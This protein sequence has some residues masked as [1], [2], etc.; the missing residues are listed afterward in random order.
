MTNE[1]LTSLGEAL[2]T[3]AEKDTAELV[4]LR[5]TLHQFPELAMDEHLTASKIAEA[6]QGLPNVRLIRGF[7]IETS[8]IAVIR[9]DIEGDAIL[10][11]AAMDG[12]Q[13]MEET[14]LDFASCDPNVCHSSGHDAEMTALVGTVKLLSRF[15]DKLT[16]RVVVLF[17]PACEG[18]N[19]ARTLMENDF[20]S[21]FG[22]TSAFAVNWSQEFPYGTLCLRDGAITAIS[23][24]IHI[25]VIGTA[26]HA[27]E[28]HLA[29][30]PIMISANILVAI[31]TMLAREIDPRD[32]AVVSFGK[33]EA[34]STYNII[35]GFAGLWGTIRTFNPDVRDFVQS[36]IETLAP[37]IAKANRGIASV[38]Y[39]RNYPNVSNDKELVKN[40]IKK[41]IPFF[42]KDGIKWLDH[43][44]LSGEDF[45]YISSAVPSVMMMLG[46]G[47]EYPLHHPRYD[48]PESMLTFA[49]AWGAYLLLNA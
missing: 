39:T 6:L 1:E 27:A 18:R 36:R 37:A 20:L 48:I 15:A 34:G 45:S 3:E 35:P 9:E 43:P 47:K 49:A 19:G 46:T 44:V 5:R 42:G 30:D 10:L 11:R 26:G 4:T 23:D 31:Q 21:H 33:I 32:V 2:L 29:V 22:I 8:V 7:A 24:K 16:K 17:E 38:E 25:D 13:V 12:E 28:P 41:A 40:I 14:G